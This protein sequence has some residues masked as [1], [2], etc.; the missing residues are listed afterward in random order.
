MSALATVDPD[1][2]PVAIVWWPEEEATVERLRVARHARLLLVAPGVAPP[3]ARHPEEDW[4]RRPVDDDDVRARIASLLDRLADGRER[5]VEIGSG[6]IRYRGRWAALSETEEALAS[7]LGADFGEVV[8]LGQLRVAGGRR[9]SDG[10]I[11]VHLTRLRKRIA[12]IG[13]VVRV[14]RGHGY[15]LDADAGP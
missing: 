2:G 14:V 10:S 15:V 5:H 9:L 6:R 1:A 12:P 8:E 7:V 3:V 4:V 13:L 11:R